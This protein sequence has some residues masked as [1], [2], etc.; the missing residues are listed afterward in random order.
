VPGLRAF[1][2]L[3]DIARSD[4]FIVEKRS[5]I[6]E[7]VIFLDG[8]SRG[9]LGPLTYWRFTHEGRDPLL[10]RYC[11]GVQELERDRRRYPRG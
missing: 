11:R 8:E 1:D 2:P 7:G 4:W 5:W 3:R 6:P 10:S 9:Y